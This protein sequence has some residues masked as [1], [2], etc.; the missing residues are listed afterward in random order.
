MIIKSIS[1]MQGKEGQTFKFLD[2]KKNAVAFAVLLELQSDVAEMKYT[3]CSLF[4]AKDRDVYLRLG[5]DSFKDESITM[6]LT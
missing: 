4:D 1:E 2:T 5:K 3:Y 6:T